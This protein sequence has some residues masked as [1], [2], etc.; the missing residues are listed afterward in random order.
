MTFGPDGNLYVTCANGTTPS[1][2]IKRFNGSTGAFIDTF[3]PT[4]SGGL[5]FPRQFVFDVGG[6]QMFVADTGLQEVLRFQGPFGA[7]PGAYID[8]Y[9]TAGQVSLPTPIG[10]AI[11]PDGDLYVGSRD[12]NKIT[13]HAPLAEAQFVVQL[14]SAS[15]GEVS[16]Q[17]STANGT[18]V[19]GSDYVATSGTLTFAP[20]QTTKTVVIGMLDD[21][22]GEPTETFFLNLSNPVN[23]TIADSQG[24]GTVLDNE[25]KFYVVDSGS[26]S[27]QTFEYGSGGTSE[28]ISTAYGTGTTSTSDTAPRGMATTAAGMMVWVVDA[29]KTVYVYNNGGALLG[30]WTAGGLNP[31]AQLE[32]LATYGTDIWLLDNKQDKVF[33]YTGAATRLSGSQ[34]A[35]SSFSLNSGNS[36]GKGIVTDGTSLWVVNDS[37]TDKVY[38]YNLSGTLLGSWTIDAANASPTGLTINP[39]NVSDIWIVDSGTKK[40]YQY[41][42]AASRTSG[43]QNAAATFGLAAGNTNPQDIADPPAPGARII[44]ARL[45]EHAAAD[46]WMAVTLPPGMRPE[47]DSV[48]TPAGRHH[49]LTPWLFG[50]LAQ[51]LPMAPPES[52]I[53]DQPGMHA[54]LALSAREGQSAEH[55][56]AS[57]RAPSYLTAG[58]RMPRHRAVDQVFSD[59]ALALLDGDLLHR[60]VATV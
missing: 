23:A 43:S 9:I 37:S 32:G 48:A 12:G 34:S 14:N 47:L 7:K 28:E 8:A 2:S 58:T 6:S 11:G 50:G 5:I 54:T 27:T 51:A 55:P 24:V 57:N 60:P 45:L 20:G 56:S 4:G 44:P 42:A 10:L 30:S 18:A 21:T 16:V 26:T 3:V 13:R 15:T 38:K 31:T 53:A 19:A 33:K 36:N 49:S 22:V 29:N 35:A 59:P 41:A 1:G 46:G 40:V 52:R 17:Y 25:T 39:T